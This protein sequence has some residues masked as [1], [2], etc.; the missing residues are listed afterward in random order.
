[1]GAIL[2]VTLQP[3]VRTVTRRTGL[4]AR[5]VAVWLLEVQLTQAQPLPLIGDGQR[6]LGQ[7]MTR[8]R[9]WASQLV[10]MLC[11]RSRELAQQIAKSATPR[12]TYLGYGRRNIILGAQKL[13]R[14]MISP[15]EG[16]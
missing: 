14:G 12:T 4:T 7:L 2:H 11:C 10:A 3:N 8:S 5:P 16:S 15:S 9:H 1:M 6:T 13:A